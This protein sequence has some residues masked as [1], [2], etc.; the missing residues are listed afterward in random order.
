MRRNHKSGA[1][2]TGGE[3]KTKEEQEQCWQ[4]HNERHIRR[5]R[6]RGQN[7]VNVCRANHSL[8]PFAIGRTL[9]EVLR[10]YVLGGCHLA[11]AHRS[12]WS[13]TSL[14]INLIISF[15]QHGWDACYRALILE[16]PPLT[17]L[18]LALDP[19]CP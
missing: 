13:T 2:N 12:L 7:K 17:R 4:L 1:K 15:S 9:R 19:P 8:T 14:V 3:L 16:L 11:S 6:W 5:N 18:S 10:H